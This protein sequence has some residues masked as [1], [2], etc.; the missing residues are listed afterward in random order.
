MTERR[1]RESDN[2]FQTAIMPMTPFSSLSIWI[3]D[4]DLGRGMGVAYNC[5]RGAQR[6]E[7]GGETRVK[8]QGEKRREET[9]GW[10]DWLL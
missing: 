3:R 6:E 4:D 8:G 7:R 10:D 2:Y 1:A 9:G 5:L